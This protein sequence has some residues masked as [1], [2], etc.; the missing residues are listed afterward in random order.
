MTYWID[1]HPGRAFCLLTFG[2]GLAVVSLSFTKLLWLDEL[3]T[4]HIARLGSATAIW[5]ALAH[6]VD[7]N[8]PLFDLVVLASLRLF[9]NDALALR[10]PAM[11]GYWV[12]MAALFGFLRRRLSGTWSLAAV[13]MSMAMAAFNYSYEGRSYGAFYGLAMLAVLCWAWAVDPSASRARRA[14]ALA[15]MVLAL[16]AGIAINYFA[17]LAFLPIAGGELA[18]SLET[19]RAHRWRKSA[20]SRAINVRVWIALVLAASSLLAYRSLIQRAITE[21]APYAWNKVSLDQVADSYTEM[22]EVILYPLLALFV[23]SFIVL[24]LSRFCSHCRVAMHPRWLGRLASQQAESRFRILPT[25]EATAV[26]LLMT[27]PILGYVVASLH[28]GM[29]SPRFV[30]PVCFGFAIAATLACYRLFGHFRMAG[31]VVLVACLVWFAARESVIGYW[32]MQQKNSFYKV[33][34]RLPAAEFPN[35]PIVI[36]DPLMAL[37]FRHYAPRNL[38]ARVVFPVDFP[39]VRLYRGE[40]SPEENLWAGRKLL[41]RMPIIPL[42]ELQHSAGKYLILASDDNW[43]VEDLLHHRYPVQRLDIN[44][45]AAAIGGFTPLAHG[46][47]VFFTSVGDRFLHTT[48]G[49][50]LAPLPFQRVANL[51]SARLTFS[52]GRPFKQRWSPEFMQSR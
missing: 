29:L 41:Y 28:G 25:H 14:W 43:L 52:G 27:Y 35:E 3:I 22:V 30:I 51:P 6:G 23:F 49:F 16:T 24:A 10:L 12:G 50:L 36:P 46:T 15:G 11:L 26:F 7:P 17:V 40:D 39:A 20:I 37:T 31:I 19:V 4:L 9:G 5:H 1:S 48:P 18:G 33:V 2:Y 13:A 8:P 44:T 21:F 38:A 47:P 45:G 32:Y 42:A 34:D